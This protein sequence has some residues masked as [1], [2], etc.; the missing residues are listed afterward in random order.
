MN[1]IRIYYTIYSNNKR[2]K[3]KKIDF[4]AF[5][6]TKNVNNELFYNVEFI[7]YNLNEIV[8]NNED[9]LLNS[10]DETIK[11]GISRASISNVANVIRRF[12][13]LKTAINI[14]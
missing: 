14:I 12:S 1:L 3:A 9:L 7:N 5:I 2:I 6:S 4:Y 8:P 13:E 10:L 11:Q